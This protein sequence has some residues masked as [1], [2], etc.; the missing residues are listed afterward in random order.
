MARGKKMQSG[1]WLVAAPVSAL[2]ATVLCWP[3]QAANT[4]DGGAGTGNWNDALN[5]DNDLVPTGTPSLTFAGGVQ[6][7]TTNNTG[8]TGVGG[9][10]FAAN[11]GSFVLAGNGLTL[12]GNVAN[13]SSSTQAI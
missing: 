6:T 2:L 3:A 11:A 1:S 4:W 13:N 7:S 5:W 8:L 9:L 12:S 10:T